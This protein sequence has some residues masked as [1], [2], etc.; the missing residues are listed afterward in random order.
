MTICCA[1]ATADGAWIGSDR[2]RCWEIQYMDNMPEKWVSVHGWWVAFAGTGRIEQPLMTIHESCGDS[3]FAFSAAFWKTVR[4]QKLVDG[5]GEWDGSL[6]LYRPDQGLWLLDSGFCVTRM[7]VGTLLAIGSGR[8]F[9]RGAWWAR[10]AV[11]DKED[12]AMAIRCACA[13][14]AGCGGEP[15]VRYVNAEGALE[16]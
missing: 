5:K 13:F 11:S 16:E 6:I 15:W 14:D 8:D 1:L 10:L 3:A 2:R 4:A 9:A 7:P 12:V